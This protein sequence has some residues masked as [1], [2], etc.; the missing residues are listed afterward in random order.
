MALDLVVDSLDAVPEAVRSL[1][2]EADGKFKLDV[3]GVEDTRGLKSALEK[4]RQAAKDAKRELE[5]ERAKLAGAD[6]EKLKALQSRYENDEEARL[7]A[8][9]KISDVIAKRTEKERAEWQ[10]INAETQAKVEAAE[11]KAKAFQGRVLDDA[12]RAAASAAGLHK[13]AI[14]DA[15]FRGRNLFTLDA[16]GNAVQLD[17]SGKPIIGKDGRTNYSPSEW[18]DSMKEQAPHWFPVNNSGS[19]GA[20]RGGKGSG[21][22]FSHLPPVERLT[23]ARAAR[24]A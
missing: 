11:A 20:G 4:E 6:I 21:K 23:A 12:I 8:D 14:E 5:A 10:R 13:H 24:K 9:G 19:S 1:Y 18:L 22:D 7:I 17:D 2:V 3:S 16:E 15:L